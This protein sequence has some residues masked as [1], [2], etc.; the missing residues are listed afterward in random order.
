MIRR[1]DPTRVITVE[2]EEVSWGATW[3]RQGLGRVR[4]GPTSFVTLQICISSSEGTEKKSRVKD[5][6][7]II[8]D[9]VLN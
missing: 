7:G 2:L 5:V 6:A 1:S 8:K 4:D 3:G 9:C